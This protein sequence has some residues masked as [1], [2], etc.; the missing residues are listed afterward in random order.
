[1]KR[2]WFFRGRI[3]LSS[4]NYPRHVYRLPSF[5]QL[6]FVIDA[7]L[8]WYK[9]YISVMQWT[10]N[11]GMLVKVKVSGIFMGHWAFPFGVTRN[12]Y[13][14]YC[15]SNA[16]FG[17]LI[18]CKIGKIV[19][20]ICQIWRQK[21]TKF[22]FGCGFAPHPAGGVYSTPPDSLARFNGASFKWGKGLGGRRKGWDGKERE[23]G[24]G[25]GGEVREIF[26][27][28]EIL[29]TWPVKVAYAVQT[30]CLIAVRT[31]ASRR[32]QQCTVAAEVHMS[33]NADRDDVTSAGSRQAPDRYCSA[34]VGS[35]RRRDRLR[36]SLPV[37]SAMNKSMEQPL[38]SLLVDRR[39]IRTMAWLSE[40]DFLT[41]RPIYRHCG[42]GIFDLWKSG[43]FVGNAYDLLL[44]SSVHENQLDVLSYHELS[45][46][47][48]C[49]WPLA[50]CIEF[51]AHFSKTPLKVEY[52]LYTLTSQKVLQ[53]YLVLFSYKLTETTNFRETPSLFTDDWFSDHSLCLWPPWIGIVFL[54]FRN[55]TRPGL[56]PNEVTSIS[57]VWAL[58]VRA[59]S[60]VLSMHWFESSQWTIYFLD[61][62][63]AVYRVLQDLRSVELKLS[64]QRSETETKHFQNSFETVLF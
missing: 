61:P 24:E 51:R 9:L 36:S 35:F 34:T 25:P 18:L 6:I 21:C 57:T 33:P 23:G 54:V 8:F 7:I 42:T 17:E 10:Y 48:N 22:D 55:E 64:A 47:T 39:S 13:Y 49:H 44:C 14:L 52:L 43:N 58:F 1:M 46:E 11:I 5:Q 27:S 4:R 12:V 29:N 30:M 2:L 60:D 56:L 16:K 40:T 38:G 37:V 31:Q 28:S 15:L 59:F 53:L 19:A 26:L 63:N 32:A 3:R 20:I 45:L 41:I 50:I 62:V